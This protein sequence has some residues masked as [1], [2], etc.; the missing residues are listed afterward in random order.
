[1]EVW[2]KPRFGP[3]CKHCHACRRYFRH[4][5]TG[6]RR[7]RASEA[8]RLEVF[9]AHDGGVTQRKLSRTHAISAATVERCYQYHIWQKRS[10]GDRRFCPGVLG[11]DEH[12][13]T[14]KRVLAHC[15]SDGTFNRVG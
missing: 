15:G 9:E 5:F 6:I 8:Y 3:A 7:Y 14:R 10:E 12:F 13:F 1:M 4:S 11:I 2:A